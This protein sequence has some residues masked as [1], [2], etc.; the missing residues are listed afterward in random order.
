MAKAWISE[1]YRKACVEGIQIHGGIGI[2]QDHDMQLYY[3]R[4]KAMEIAFGDPDYHLELVAKEMGL[5]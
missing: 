1:A 3:R 5:Y 2:T 4:A